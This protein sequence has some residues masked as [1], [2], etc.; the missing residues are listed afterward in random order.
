MPLQTPFYSWSLV[1][2]ES[3][4]HNTVRLS[5]VTSPVSEVPE[6]AGMDSKILQKQQLDPLAETAL[7][8]SVCLLADQGRVHPPASCCVYKSPVPIRKSVQKTLEK[9]A[10][11]TAKVRL[12]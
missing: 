1:A 11:L 6:E 3:T 8:S 2:G 7:D 5:K 9:T 4:A 12:T 10:G